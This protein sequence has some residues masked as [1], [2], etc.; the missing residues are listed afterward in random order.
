[1]KMRNIFFTFLCAATM[2]ARAQSPF[3]TIDSIDANSINA[4]VLVHGD[5]WWNPATTGNMWWIPATSSAKFFFPNGTAK[6]ISF[7]AA[8]WISAYDNAGQLHVAAQA[9][10][11]DGNDYWPGPLDASGS[12]DYAT[13]EKWAKVW[14]VR[15]SEVDA[16]R[17]ITFHNTSNT[18]ESILTWPAKGNVYAK[19]K[20]GAP[21]SITEDMAPFVDGNG[22]GIYSPLKGDY[23]D[24]PGEQALWWV[25]SDNGPTHDQTDG[26]PLK[27]QVHAMAY[28]FKR[29]TL[30]DHVVYYNY[31][32][33]NKSAN[34]YHDMRLALWD[35]VDKGFSFDQ[36]IALDSARRMGIIYNGTNDDGGTAG[37]P[38][39]SYGLP[40]TIGFTII[41]MPG[42]E[43]AALRP[44]NSF[45]YFNNDPS[46]IGNPTVDTQYS[47]YMRAKIRNGAPFLLPPDPYHECAMGNSTGDRRFVLATNDFSLA[48][49]ANTA[50]TLALVVD[51]AAGGCP[52]V[53]FDGIREVADTAWGNWSGAVATPH[54]SL[55][56]SSLS[57]YP[58]PTSSSINIDIPDVHGDYYLGICNSIGSNVYRKQCTGSHNTIDVSSLPPG[59]YVLRYSTSGLSGH[60]RFVKQ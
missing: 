32:V 28:A 47:N 14:K 8:L 55:P 26:N 46:I 40:L 2:C 50:L 49:G 35:D 5:M 34:N 29:N 57:I 12:L 36:Y 22:D 7:A 23:P 31:Q 20:D 44:V 15:R 38:S 51:S 56:Q 24:F 43:G 54:L 59:V 39:N 60:A 3:N 30:I 21:L 45:T 53:S 19:G 4:S 11:Q 18:P 25:F 48:A 16:H 33:V 13:S 9:Y 52:G 42:D 6:T 37:H 27:V 41:S 17:A 10:R 1:M 58:D